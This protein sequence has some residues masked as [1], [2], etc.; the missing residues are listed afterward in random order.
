[1]AHQPIK[2]RTYVL[3]YVIL[4]L[5]TGTTVYLASQMHLGKAEIPV[6]LGIAAVKTLLV[7]I[8][9]MHLIHSRP[10]TWVI[11]ATGLLFLFALIA[12]TLTDYW[13]RGWMP[14]RGLPP[15]WVWV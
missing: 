15:A 7:G 6:A 10:L 3:I 2:P 8:F 14:V 13:T 1:M 12:I 4:L 5:L 9:F 11:I